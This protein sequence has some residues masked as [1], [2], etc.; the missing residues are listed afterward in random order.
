MK[1]LFEVY[2]WE[3]VKYFVFSKERE[4]VYSVDRTYYAPLP[5]RVSYFA[6]A[7]GLAVSY[8]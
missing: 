6:N 3:E 4:Y 2:Q 8:L 7:E 1:D 5:K